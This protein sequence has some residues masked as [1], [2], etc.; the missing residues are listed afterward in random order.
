M[1]EAIYPEGLISVP[2]DPYFSKY[3]FVVGKKER[4][5]WVYQKDGDKLKIV[6]KFETDVG[7]KDGEKT[8]A[9][10]HKTPTGIYFLLKHMSQP[11]IPFS[12]YG[13]QAFSTD[14]PN[15]FDKREAKTG[16]GIWLHA[17]P[18]NVPLTRGSRGCV[19]V[20][21]DV[22][23]KLA[24]YVK[25][26]QTPLVIF[27]EVKMLTYA[28]HLENKKKHLE[29]FE[30]WRSTWETQDV[31]SYIRFYDQTFRNDQM[32]YRQWYRHKKRMK[33]LYTE[34]KVEL[35]APLI[36][37][38]KDQV[39]LRTIQHYKSNLHEDRGEKT[40]HARATPEDGLF[41]YKIIRE[42]WVD[43]GPKN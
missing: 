35:S 2:D 39:V 20:R 24:P 12:L 15:I 6:E 41:G 30:K 36:I 22:I 18:D 33:A 19:V 11:E 1:E 16:S 13:S 14:Y 42:D 25:L 10:D 7:K 17:V 31:D 21:N 28:Q 32:S 3:V 43:L 27:N 8:K 37:A 40:I 34:I 9:N 5:L 23:K 29:F 26:G 4:V 38:N